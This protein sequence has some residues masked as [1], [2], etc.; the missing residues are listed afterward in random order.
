MEEGQVTNLT[1]KHAFY[2]L[3][4]DF[5]VLIRFTLTN[6]WWNLQVFTLTADI[7]NSIVVRH[8][9]VVMERTPSVLAAI[10]H[11]TTSLIA[12]ASQ[13]YKLEEEQVKVSEGLGLIFMLQDGKK[14]TLKWKFR[15]T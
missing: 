8:S 12:Q 9:A 10:T 4:I 3:K 14:I 15:S 11:L 5:F 13:E 1:Q 6:L 7:V 2:K